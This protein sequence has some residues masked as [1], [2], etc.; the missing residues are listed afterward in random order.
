MKKPRRTK[1]LK[2]GSSK[3]KPQGTITDYFSNNIV[4]GAQTGRK[5]KVG[6]EEDATMLEE[7]TF[8]KIRRST[9]LK[10]D[11]QGPKSKIRDYPECQDP[12][13]R[14]LKQELPRDLLEN[15]LLPRTFIYI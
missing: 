5:R 2:S 8:K 15:C 11:V 9:I 13:I 12:T 6:G 10:P 7:R 3:T 1:K 4:G 14:T